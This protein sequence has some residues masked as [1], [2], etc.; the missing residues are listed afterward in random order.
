MFTQTSFPFTS[1][2]T[3]L[4]FQNIELWIIAA[5]ILAYV[6]LKSQKWTLKFNNQSNNKFIKINEL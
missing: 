2:A 3:N 5:F 6:L 1:K 4:G